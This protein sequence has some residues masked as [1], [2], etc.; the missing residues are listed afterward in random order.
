MVVAMR[1]FA[2]LSYDEIGETLGMTS[3]LV[4]VTLLRARRHLRRMLTE[5]KQS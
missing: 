3:S 4:G 1:Y 2:E 5:M